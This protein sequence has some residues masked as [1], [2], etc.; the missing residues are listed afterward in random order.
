MY[1]RNI[2][3][4]NEYST[5]LIA[6]RIRTSEIEFHQFTTVI[7][8]FDPLRLNLK[9]ISTVF[10]IQDLSV[11]WKSWTFWDWIWESITIYW[12][13]F[14]F[15]LLYQDDLTV[16]LEQFT[17]LI[18]WLGPLARWDPGG[19]IPQS[20]P[21]PSLPRWWLCSSSCSG[22]RLTLVLMI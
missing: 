14:T 4:S 21:L 7:W 18:M 3:F 6:G 2:L 5:F 22:Y 10:F 12:I 1:H 19:K 11:C 8:E 13:P 9:V 20:S 15:W 16:L 17:F